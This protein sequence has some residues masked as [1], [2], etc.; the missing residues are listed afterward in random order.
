MGRVKLEWES[1]RGESSSYMVVVAH[2]KVKAR[3]GSTVVYLPQAY[4]IGKGSGRYWWRVSEDPDL[5]GLPH[6]L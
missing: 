5:E 3:G 6:A 1:G 4:G 2:G